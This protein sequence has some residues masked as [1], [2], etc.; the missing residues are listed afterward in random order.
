MIFDTKRIVTGEFKYFFFKFFLY[1]KRTDDRY[2][3]IVRF[4]GFT[5]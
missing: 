5:H 4:E 1:F 3:E 2:R